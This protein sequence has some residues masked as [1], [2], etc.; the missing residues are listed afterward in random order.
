MTSEDITPEHIALYHL[1]KLTFSERGPFADRSQFLI[2]QDRANNETQHMQRELFGEQRTVYFCVADVS[3]GHPA[4]RHIPGIHK[5]GGGLGSHN[6]L[7]EDPD[8]LH[9]DLD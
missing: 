4:N 1:F 9:Y 2:E 6:L 7:W 5:L 3:V 8:P